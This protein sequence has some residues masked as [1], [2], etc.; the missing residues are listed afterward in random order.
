MQ[1]D[2]AGS[3][4]VDGDSFT[5]SNG[6]ETVTFEFNDVSGAASGVKPGNVEVPYR[7]TDRPGEVADAIRNAVN[8]GEIRDVLQVQATS[9]GGRLNDSTDPVII[10]HGFAAADNLGG[11]FF[12]SSNADRG[13]YVGLLD[14]KFEHN[15]NNSA[16]NLNEGIWTEVAGLPT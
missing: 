12:G 10:F 7:R 1:V 8:L 2:S 4:I 6:S 16:Q 13:D 14:E 5:L 11:V 15:K 9:Q 3:D